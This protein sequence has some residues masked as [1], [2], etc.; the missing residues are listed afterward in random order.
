MTA[1]D[2]R[3]AK[4]LDEELPLMAPLRPAAQTLL[5]AMTLAAI[6]AVGVA[7]AWAGL[8]TSDRLPL[9][10][11]LAGGVTL[12]SL[13]PLPFVARTKLYLDTA[14]LL[15]AVLLL[16]PAAALLVAA[17]G[18][19]LGEALRR[20]PWDQTVF[21]GAQATL[22]AATGSA[23]LAAAGWRVDHFVFAGPQP[24]LLALVAAAAMWLVNTF[25]TATIVGLQEGAP[26]L[27]FWAESFNQLNHA[28][29]AAELVQ[30]AIGI[31]AAALAHAEGWL[32]AL[33][34]LP[35]GAL[36]QA[37]AHHM[38]RRRAAEARLLH[39]AYHDPLTE[40]PNRALFLDRLTQALARASRRGEPLAI[41][42]LDL[43]RFKLVNDSLGHAV[44][45]RLLIAVGERLRDCV[46]P[47]DTVARLG[48]DEFT[49][50]L[51]GL[52]DRTEAE[53]M[54][55]AV[56]SALET[57]FALAGREAAVTASIGVAF[58]GEEHGRPEDLLRDA[59]V[60]LYRAKQR[61]KACHAIFEGSM[62]SGLRE[63]V[64]LE[65]D[66]RRALDGRALT[67]AYQPIVALAT[68]HLVTVEALA[69]WDHPERGPI[70]P[71]EFIAVA[72]DAGLIGALGRWALEEACVQ[73]RA[74]VERLPE[75]LAVSVN[76]S[77]RQFQEPGLVEAVAGLVQMAGLTPGQLQLEIT[78]SAVM[79][80]LE[81][82]VRTLRQLKGL[83]TRIALDD[84][85]TGYSSLSYLRRLPIDV[86][87]ID[88]SFIGG[89][90]RDA[91]DAAIV[92]AMLAVARAMGLTV[93]AE[94][95]ETAGQVARLRELGC[96]LGQGFY[97]GA[98]QPAAAI[99]TLLTKVTFAVGA[100]ARPAG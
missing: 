95:V 41:L 10:L 99:E 28:E 27:A 47:G 64:A 65:A 88:R 74:W 56:A 5:A 37:L 93:V 26:V 63:R 67:L 17:S 57:P 60:A 32:A 62:R 14:I 52:A 34:L 11:V 76:L 71:S 97:F 15:A 50:L 21:N 54:V 90:E 45:D 68:G 36:Y 13:F 48:G 23:V 94:G 77:A 58:A 22:Q 66:L 46:R 19:L 87:K 91:G 89:L 59:D 8:P 73:G 100:R 83:G 33:L 49:I 82:A 30:V 80:D 53:A 78:E 44:G 6:A 55:A 75:P 40:L 70:P 1:N 9:T 51:D 43:D 35:T 2:Q 61:G 84:F 31:L 72:E 24:L 4:D 98:P 69:R 92:E 3:E 96:D 20:Q 38:L 25:T 7:L 42:F 79:S 81:A 29:A 39:Q 18:V 86:L 12:A 85:G 16:E